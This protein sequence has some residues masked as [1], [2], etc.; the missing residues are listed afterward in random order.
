[1]MI[2]L[3]SARLHR[4]ELRA[5]MPFRY[6]IATMTDV[7]QVILHA[8]FEL[9]GAR[10]R[11]LAAD[12]LPPKWFTK[13]P[14]RGLADEVDEMLL[15]IRSQAIEKI[16][17]NSHSDL[18]NGFLMLPHHS[19]ESALKLDTHGHRALDHSLAAAPAAAVPPAAVPDPARARPAPLGRR[20]RSG[21]RRR[22]SRSAGLGRPPAR[23]RCPGR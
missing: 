17:M 22:E 6:G 1:M 5:R 20:R 9:N 18:M 3:L 15:V 4:L 7:P 11:G 8:E 21:D 13:D 10:H 19:M 16:G 23:R 2:R 12:L 14:A